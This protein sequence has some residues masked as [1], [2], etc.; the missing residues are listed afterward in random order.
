MVAGDVMHSNVW[1]RRPDGSECTP[2]LTTWLDRAAGRLRFDVHIV[3][4]GEGI[5]QEHLCRSFKNM[6][7]DPPWGTAFMALRRQR[8]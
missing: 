8:S 4:R 2:K 5:R 7:A 6:A 3:P 1:F